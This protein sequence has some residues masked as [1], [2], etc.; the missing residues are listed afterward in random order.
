[1]SYQGVLARGYALV[2]DGNGKP[3][4][5]ALTVRPTDALTLMFIDGD[6][7]AHADG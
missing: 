2:L 6:I 4:R 5:S 3:V 1:V 7:A